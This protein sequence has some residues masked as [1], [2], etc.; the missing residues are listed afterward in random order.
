MQHFLTYLQEDD[1]RKVLRW[2]QRDIARYIHAQ[3]QEHHW[4]EAGGYE[5]K[6]TKGFT[7]LRKSAYTA[8]GKDIALDYKVSPQDK[9]NMAKYLFSGYRYCL[10]DTPQ[11]FQSDTERRLTVILEREEMKWFRPARGQFQIFYKSGADQLEYQPDFV[12]EGGDCIY[13]LEPKASREMEDQDVLAKRSAATQW[14]Q[15]A[16][17]HAAA[18]GGKVWKYVLIPHEAVVDN[19]TITGLAERFGEA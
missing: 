8:G 13:M 9:S 15:L 14:C 10:F 2:Y 18:N 11:K 16:S 17:D 1:A 3:M 5:V 19:M 6:V 4:E 7:E 12:A